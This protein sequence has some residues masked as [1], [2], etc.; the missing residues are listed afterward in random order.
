LKGAID[1]L[2]RRP[3]EDASDDRRCLPRS[4]AH[5]LHDALY[6]GEAVANGRLDQIRDRYEEFPWDTLTV[7]D[8][9]RLRLF[10]PDDAKQGAY[11]LDA[12]ELADLM[13][14]AYQTE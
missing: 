5:V 10:R 12:M 14:N 7:K 9:E 11:L 4:Q 2:V 13:A 3:E 8:N 1:A 6:M